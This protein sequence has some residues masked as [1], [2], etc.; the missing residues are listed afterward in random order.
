MG[1]LPVTSARHAARLAAL[2]RHLEGEGAAI[3]P[4]PWGTH[5]I[6]WPLP[7]QP[8]PVS[9]LIPAGQQAEPLRRCVLSL[10]GS[11]R[12]AQRHV[13]I[14][15][16]G[17]P[18]PDMERYLTRI[19]Q[20]P[21]VTVLRLADAPSTA[22][23]LNRA[24][25]AAQGRFLCLMSPD[26]EALD[27]LWLTSMVRHA[28]REGVGAVGA[29]LLHYDGTIRHAGLVLGLGEGA[30]HAHHLQPDGQPGYFAQA[31]VTRQA[32]AV[33]GACLLVDRQAFESVGGLD[34]EA[35]A[36]AWHDVDLCLRLQGAGLRNIYVPEAVLLHHDKPFTRRRV[37]HEG[38]LAMLRSRWGPI[39]SA[40]PCITVIWIGRASGIR[41]GCEGLKK[42]KRQCEGV[43]VGRMSQE[44]CSGPSRSH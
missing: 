26:V 31:H 32:T 36:N 10:L 33:S 41:C 42:K 15:S 16:H 17:M 25:R 43:F 23:L 7:D 5:R 13:V 3:A 37:S 24:A 38:E 4:G 6:A 29:K 34:E 35:F 8:E 22:A 11:T 40:I 18:G 1:G 9:I 2:A 21:R 20:N 44:T 19:A 14:A 39:R 12:Y 28:R 30:G 27:D